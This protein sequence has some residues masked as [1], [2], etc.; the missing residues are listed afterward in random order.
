[1]DST[2]LERVREV[3]IRSAGISGDEMLTAETQIVGSGL[4]LDSVATVELLVGLENEFG[5]IISPDELLKAE[6]F[7][8]VGAL[9]G[10]IE[11]RLPEKD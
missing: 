5:I 3:I 1:M 6:A 9:V 8:T 7:R 4:A 2:V 11:A 10:F